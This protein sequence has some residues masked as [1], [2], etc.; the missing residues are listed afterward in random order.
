VQEKRNGRI[1]RGRDIPNNGYIDAQ[2]DF[3]LLSRFLRSMDYG[4]FKLLPPAK[5]KV[6]NVTYVV[7]KYGIESEDTYGEK[8]IIYN[9][10]TDGHLH[11]I[12]FQY[13]KGKITLYL[14][15]ENVSA[16]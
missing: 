5:M 9:K 15:E 3:P 6:D 12:E 14:Q 13:K 11:T 16:Q 8:R 4:I 2:W 1:Y 10:K 7:K